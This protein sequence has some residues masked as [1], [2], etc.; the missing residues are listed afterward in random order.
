MLVFLIIMAFSLANVNPFLKK[1]KNGDFSPFLLL[2]VAIHA[3]S[4]KKRRLRKVNFSVNTQFF[5][6]ILFMR[7]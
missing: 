7:P 6:R 5:G 2:L 3:F 4:A 1:S